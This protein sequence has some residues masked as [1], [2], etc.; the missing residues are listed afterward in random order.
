MELM[1][2]NSRDCTFSLRRQIISCWKYKAESNADVRGLIN[3][4]DELHRNIKYVEN[5]AHARIY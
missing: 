4:V 1:W 2:K 5:I 3:L